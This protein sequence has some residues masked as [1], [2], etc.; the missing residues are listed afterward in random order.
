MRDR[1][2]LVINT[3]AYTAVDA[4][5]REVERAEAVNVLGAANV[6]EGAG[7]VGARMIQVS[8][9]F[10]FDGSQGRPY[11][12]ED[13]PRPLGVYGRTKLAGEREVAGR[14]GSRALILRTAW[15]YSGRGR[16]FVL[17]MLSAMKEREEVR[18]VSDQIGTP[19]WVRS[20]ADALWAA[21]GQSSLHGVHHWTDAGVA[22]WFDFAAAIQEEALSLGLLQ[23]AVPIR[24]LRTEQYPTLARRPSYSVLDKSETW[25][26]LKLYPPHWRVNLR[27]MLQGLSSG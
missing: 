12:V 4:A 17:T 16:N 25:A 3:A 14:L 8:T 23:R 11:T 13:P 21:A 18:V 20:L 24:A 19:T 15:L 22:S 6:A 5:E 2:T 27:H 9:D 10:V 7:R 1:P 26:A